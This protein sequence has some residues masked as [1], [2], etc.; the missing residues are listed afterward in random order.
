M[1]DQ[2]AFIPREAVSRF[3]L[4]CTQCQKK[5]VGGLVN[6]FDIKSEPL[7]ELEGKPS[8]PQLATPPATPPSEAASCYTG[9]PYI[10]PPQGP[11]GPHAALA[12]A[13]VIRS[14]LSSHEIN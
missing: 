8:T 2:Y 1:A 13:Q 9:L 5:P 10:L 11:I 12:Y 3:L 6:N 14:G 4:H 7:T